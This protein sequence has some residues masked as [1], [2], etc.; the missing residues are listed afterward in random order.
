MAPT[1]TAEGQ[2]AASMQVVKRGHQVQVEEIPDDED[3]MS[4]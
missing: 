4:F 3:D 2:E 1:K